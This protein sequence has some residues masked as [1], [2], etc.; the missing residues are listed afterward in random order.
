ML[1]MSLNE[2]MNVNLFCQL[3]LSM[4]EMNVLIQRKFF[5][6]NLFMIL[7]DSKVSFWNKTQLKVFF[8]FIALQ[9]ALCKYRIAQYKLIQKKL[10]CL[11]V[12]T[13]RL[14]ILV[15]VAKQSFVCL[16]LTPYVFLARLYRPRYNIQQCLIYAFWHLYSVYKDFYC[17]CYVLFC[18]PPYSE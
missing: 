6:V 5:T 18:E 8:L 9:K 15:C 13:L 17:Q 14:Y 7:D 12:K 2:N 3:C 1:E 16:G 4:L 10:V 11:K